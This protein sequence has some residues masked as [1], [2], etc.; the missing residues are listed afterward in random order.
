M[1]LCFV[2]HFVLQPDVNATA[3]AIAAVCLHPAQ[4]KLLFLVS[5]QPVPLPFSL[6]SVP[7]V[8]PILVVFLSWLEIPT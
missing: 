5:L 2:L 3:A 6:L 8:G 7:E 1:R 4:H